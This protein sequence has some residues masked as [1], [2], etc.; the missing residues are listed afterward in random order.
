MRQLQM[1]IF[2]MATCNRFKCM[3]RHLMFSGGKLS[4]EV[5]R[6]SLFMASGQYQQEVFLPGISVLV[7]VE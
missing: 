5:D 7:G 2:G 3:C 4:R 1:P 6:W